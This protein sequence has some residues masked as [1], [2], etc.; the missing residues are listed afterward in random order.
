MHKLIKIH[1]SK[2]AIK[3][4]KGWFAGWDQFGEAKFIDTV[5]LAELLPTAL[6]EATVTKLSVGCEDIE[7][8]KVFIDNNYIA[9]CW[10]ELEIIV[11][12]RAGFEYIAEEKDTINRLIQSSKKSCKAINKYQYLDNWIKNLSSP[13]FSHRVI[14]ERVTMDAENAYYRGQ[15]KYIA[16]DYCLLKACKLLFGA[17]RIIKNIEHGI[18]YANNKTFL[19]MYGKET[20]TRSI[21]MKTETSDGTIMTSSLCL[22]SFVYNTKI[23]VPQLVFGYISPTLAVPESWSR[24]ISKEKIRSSSEF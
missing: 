6:A 15:R 13:T 5:E 12:K 16:G 22:D 21:N 24:Q 7:I 19:D 9:V 20:V 23:R 10:D 11:D 3:T 4:D 1:Y 8:V 17:N 14:D 18:E 2:R